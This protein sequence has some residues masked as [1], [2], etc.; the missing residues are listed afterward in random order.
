MI[1]GATTHV[2]RKRHSCPVTVGGACASGPRS[3]SP[4]TARRARVYGSPAFSSP[5]RREPAL[6]LTLSTKRR[7]W[8]AGKRWSRRATR[9]RTTRRRAWPPRSRSW[10]SARSWWRPATPCSGS[11]RPESRPRPSPTPSKVTP[12]VLPLAAVPGSLI[13]GWVGSV[14]GGISLRWRRR[15]PGRRPRS[16]C[17][18]CRRC[19]TNATPSRPSSLACSH[20]RGR[21]L[22]AYFAFILFVSFSLLEEDAPL[23]SV[24]TD[25]SCHFGGPGSWRFRLRSSLRRLDLLLACVAQW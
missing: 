1:F 8:R 21:F 7:P 22:C 19:S 15:A 20:R 13:W 25:Q 12:A 23:S 14:Q 11:S 9:R 2:P 24:L 4:V 17:P 10:G 5:R 3:A 18:S 6:R 16:R